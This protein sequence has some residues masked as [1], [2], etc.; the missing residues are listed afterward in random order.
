MQAS[1]CLLHSKLFDLS[2]DVRYVSSYTYPTTYVQRSL[3]PAQGKA[4]ILSEKFSTRSLVGQFGLVSKSNAAWSAF[5]NANAV[6]LPSDTGSVEVSTS[7]SVTSSRAYE[8]QGQCDDQATFYIDG[9]VVLTGGGFTGAPKSAV[10][11]LT[12]GVHTLRISGVNNGWAAGVA[13]T[14]RNTEEGLTSTFSAL[15]LTGSLTGRQNKFW[16]GVLA[17][18][19]H[20]YFVPSQAGSIG[21]FVPS[22]GAFS[23]I[24]ISSV[25]VLPYC[26][27]VLAPN[28][29]LYFIP[30]NADNIGVFNPSTRDFSVIDISS[31]IAHDAKYVGGVLAPNGHIYFVPYNADSIGDFNPNTGAF[32]VISISVSLCATPLHG[33]K[34]EGGVLAPDGHIYFVPHNANCIGDFDPATGIFTFIDISSFIAHGTKYVGG[35]LAPNGLIYFVPTNADNIGVFNPSTHAFSVIDI[36]SVIV[37]DEKYAGG[38]LA[39]NGHIYFVPYNADSIGVFNPSTGAFSVIDISSVIT[40]GNKYIGGVLSPNGHIYLVP[41]SADSIGQI[42]LRNQEPAYN[43]SGGVPVTWD[44]VLSPYFNKL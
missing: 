34:Y 41:C 21:D 9:N 4:E 8:V 10:I 15:T 11:S 5:M 32:S 38:V 37:Q 23:L 19:G 12:A 36:S 40:T 14:L 20:I 7:L 39:P 30:H 13:F 16:G 33:Y 29:L 44:A 17:P 24:G 2:A 6:W 28:G 18:N 27:V 3:T 35:V 22:T 1:D 31:V 26:G 25:I 42:Y 43:V